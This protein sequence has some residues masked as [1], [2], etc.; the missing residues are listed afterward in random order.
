ML[1]WGIQQGNP[2]GELLHEACTSLGIPAGW[3]YRKPF[4][5]A[6][7]MVSRGYPSVFYGT[8]EFT[9]LIAESKQW[10][11]GIWEIDD[12]WLQLDGLLNHD[13]V[14]MPLK[15]IP[16]YCGNS[17][18]FIR[19]VKDDKFFSGQ[20]MNKVEMDLWI[21]SLDPEWQEV[22]ALVS[23]PK[24][25]PHEWRCFMVNGEFISGSHY[26]SYGMKMTSPDV[27]LAVQEFASNFPV[28]FSHGIYVLDVCEFNNELKLVEVNGF[29]SCGFYDTDVKKVV[30]AINNAKVYI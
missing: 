3:I 6:L 15:L 11:P 16:E 12:Q 17:R 14:R 22:H 18:S 21:Q 1:Y 2:D 4:S 8:V 9:N 20:V 28:S 26:R 7:P 13:A 19:P 23:I 30:E 24:Q 25:I 10:T 27:P 5:L 29:N